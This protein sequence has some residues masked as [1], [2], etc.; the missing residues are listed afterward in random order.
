MKIA[1]S[2]LSA[3]FAALGEAIARV[4]S[5]GADLLHVDVMDGH[6][7]PNITYGLPI[8]EAVRRASGLPIEAH[9]MISDPGAYAEQFCDAGADII[10]FHIEAQANPGPLLDRLH[11]RGAG[12][13]LAINPQTPLSAILP[14]LERC[15]HVLVMSV[16]PGFGGQAFEYVA[17]DR[18][19]ELDQCRPD[20][21][22]LEVDGGVNASTIG[23]CAEAGARLHVVGSAIFRQPNSYEQSVATLT[24]LARTHHRTP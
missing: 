1:P 20:G 6:F 4:E 19:R 14:W 2:I 17:L 9:L 21:L 13:G 8:V 5:A 24:S 23:L 12:A 18:L 22:V 16:T 10:T 7:V 3:D 11:A 15:D